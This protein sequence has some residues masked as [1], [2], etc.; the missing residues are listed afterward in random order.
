MAFFS[1]QQPSSNPTVTAVA[2]Q[3]TVVPYAGTAVAAS[4]PVG[5]YGYNAGFGYGVP[6]YNNYGVGALGA[7]QPWYVG[8][9]HN[10]GTYAFQSS[11]ATGFPANPFIGAGANPTNMAFRQFNQSHQRTVYQGGN[12]VF[13]GTNPWQQRRW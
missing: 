8:Q 11:P 4:A 10:T 6:S 7:A 3:S 13:P 9:Q 1:F 2:A 5:G 12:T